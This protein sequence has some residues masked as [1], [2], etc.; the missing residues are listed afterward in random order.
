ML[1]AYGVPMSPSPATRPPIVEGH[2]PAVAVFMFDFARTGVVVNAVR[3]ANALAARGHRVTLLVMSAQGRQ[4]HAIDPAVDIEEAGGLAVRLKIARGPALLAGT[5]AL[6]QTLR[7]VAPDILLSAGNHA[8][9]AAILASRRMPR[10]KRVLRISIELDHPGDGPVAAWCRRLVRNA[11]FRRADRLLLVS[12]HLARYPLL[13]SALAQGRAVVAQNGVALEKVRER[14][15]LPCRHPW[16]DGSVPV[17]MAV[18]RLVPHKNLETLVRAFATAVA[19]RPLRLLIVGGGAPAE[20]RRLE[21]LAAGLGVAGVVRLEGE[22]ADPV[23]LIAGAAA[24]V[25]P[26]LWEGASNV[27]LEALACGVPLVA[28]RSAGNAQEVLGYGRFGLLVDPLD[29]RGMALAILSQ[30]S[31]DPV[32]PGARAADFP[33]A[34]ALARACRAVT[35]FAADDARAGPAVAWPRRA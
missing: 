6:R 33:A 34:V 9:L 17:V 35:D 15:G 31:A 18:G 4:A 28:A 25:L 1:G 5:A 26:S 16:F 10:L 29:V 19:Q 32:R 11:I 27:L 8:H 22:C 12:A 7:R 13:E 23:P 2:Q 24:F 21:S 14:A 3:L 20:R 30:T